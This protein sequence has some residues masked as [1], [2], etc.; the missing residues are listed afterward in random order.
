MGFIWVIFGM[1]MGL[2]KFVSVDS[3][4]V[5]GFVPAKTC[6]WVAGWRLLDGVD[7]DELC[8]R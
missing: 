1:E 5:D 4:N 6:F 7:V 3:N 8:I 2:S